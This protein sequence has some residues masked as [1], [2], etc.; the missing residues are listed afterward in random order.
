MKEQIASQYF[1]NVIGTLRLILDEG[2]EEQKLLGIPRID[3]PAS[4]LTR[5]PI[6]QKTLKL[7]EKNHFKAIVAAVRDGG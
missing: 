6:R 4:L 2:I 5:A 1:N 3:N 7:P